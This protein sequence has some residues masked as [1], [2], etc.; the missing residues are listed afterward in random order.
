MFLKTLVSNT[1]IVKLCPQRRCD[2][3]VTALRHIYFLII[4]ESDFVGE[5]LKTKCQIS[6]SAAP[7]LSTILSIYLSRPTSPPHSLLLRTTLVGT[8]LDVTRSML[9]VAVIM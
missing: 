7:S 9:R 6:C 4:S 5:N 1:S 3:H 2:N 8:Q